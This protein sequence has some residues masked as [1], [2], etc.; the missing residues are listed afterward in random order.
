MGIKGLFKFIG[1]GFKQI[2]GVIEGLGIDDELIE[3]ALKWIRIADQKY[4]DNDQR[5]EWVVGV[6]KGRNLPDSIARLVVELAFQVYRKE[7]KK[8]GI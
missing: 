5:R 6:L 3:F 1:K 7:K 8:Q 4:V 2:W